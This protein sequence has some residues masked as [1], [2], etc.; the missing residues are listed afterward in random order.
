MDEQFIVRQLVEEI[1]ERVARRMCGIVPERVYPDDEAAELIGY[2][3]ARGPQNL[4]EVEPELLP[5]TPISP[6]GRVVGFLGR[7][8][9]AY[10]ELQRSKANPHLR[11]VS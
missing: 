10:I 7:D 4:R 1:A 8:L 3:S 5:R 9:L 6:N 11:K 2:R